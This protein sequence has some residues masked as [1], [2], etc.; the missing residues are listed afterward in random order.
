MI[1]T[2][3][4]SVCCEHV[5]DRTR[6]T[7]AVATGISCARGPTGQPIGDEGAGQ[8]ESW[9]SVAGK[10]GAGPPPDAGRLV[11]GRRHVPPHGLACTGT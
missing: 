6:A 7:M 4:L 10:L 1:T 5:L 3:A 9:T 8:R 11:A 2:G